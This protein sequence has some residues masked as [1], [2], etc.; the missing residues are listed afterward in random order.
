MVGSQ[1]LRLK[2]DGIGTGCWV[3]SAAFLAVAAKVF[4][5][6][7]GRFAVAPEIKTAAMVAGKNGRRKDFR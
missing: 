2:L 4:L 6:A 7:I 5:F 3:L 1:H